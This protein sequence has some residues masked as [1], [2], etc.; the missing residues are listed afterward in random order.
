MTDHP[1]AGG[2]VDV[3]D[4][5]RL[6]DEDLERKFHGMATKQMDDEQVDELIETVWNVES[7]DDVGDLARLMVPP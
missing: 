5:E 4:V 3:A 1:M 2:D 6:S 7:L